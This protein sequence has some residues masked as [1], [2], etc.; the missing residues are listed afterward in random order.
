MKNA[1]QRAVIIANGE[2][3][4]PDKIRPLIQPDDKIIC[5]DGGGYHAKRMGLVPDVIIGDMDSVSTELLAEFEGMGTLI[6]THP[7]NKDETD[8][9]LAIN[10]ASNSGIQNIDVIGVFGGRLDQS[11]ANLMLLARPEWRHLRLRAITEHEVTWPLRGSDQETITGTVGDTLS[12]IP[13]TPSVEGVTLTGVKW[14]LDQATLQFGSTWTMSNE[15]V[16]NEVTLS[17]VQGLVLIVQGRQDTNRRS[18]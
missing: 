8:L 7:A 10:F 6:E 18:R 3:S 5:A 16:K 14:P 1:Q 9:E 2:L 15:F 4:S 13:L 12:L 17:V 11:V